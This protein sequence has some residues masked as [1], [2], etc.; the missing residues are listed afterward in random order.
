MFVGISNNGIFT[1]IDLECIMKVINIVND[2]LRQLDYE[3]S[4]TKLIISFYLSILKGN[5]INN[6]I[7]INIYEKLVLDTISCIPWVSAVNL[8][9]VS[10]I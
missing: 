10:I 9:D 6:D 1:N 4:T 3:D 7:K 2:F 8:N 5:L